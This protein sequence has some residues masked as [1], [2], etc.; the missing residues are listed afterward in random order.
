MAGTAAYRSH[1]LDG[2]ESLLPPYL[3]FVSAHKILF[4]L[5]LEAASGT[6]ISL[7]S[8]YPSL[9]WHL[10]EASAI[11]GEIRHTAASSATTSVPFTL[12]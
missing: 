3:T 9:C 10:T 6:L 4:K 11:V 7:Y 1:I 5:A 8:S 2:S 12:H